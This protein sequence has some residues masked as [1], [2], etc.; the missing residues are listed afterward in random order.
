MVAYAIPS[1]EQEGKADTVFYSVKVDGGRKIGMRARLD[2]YKHREHREGGREAVSV[3][4]PVRGGG[5]DEDQRRSMT[6]LQVCAHC[7]IRARP[8]K[9]GAGGGTSGSGGAT[10]DDGCSSGMTSWLSVLN[11]TGDPI[12][13]EVSGIWAFEKMAV[14]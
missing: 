9:L 3:K 10:Y 11:P 2:S 8:L 1:K 7:S 5:Q 13:I 4:P 12:Q 14:Y 6:V